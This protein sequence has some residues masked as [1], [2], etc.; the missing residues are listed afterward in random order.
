M[1][2]LA[3][4]DWDRI[5][6]DLDEDGFALTGPIFSEVECGGLT[7]SYD[8]DGAFRS[9]VIM[10]RHGFGLGEYR[11]FQYPLPPI[12]AELRQSIY[13]SLAPLANRWAEAMR[14]EHRYPA[15]LD[16][17]TRRCH[18]A[19]QIK[20]TPLL[21]RYGPGDYNRL[22]RD[23]YGPLAFPIQMTVMLSDPAGFQG[24]EFMLVENRPRMQARGE[25]ITL[26]QGEAVLFAVDQRPVQGTR[27]TF[28][29]SMR[30]GVSRLRSGSRH[31][32]GVI[33]HDAA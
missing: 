7:E 26:G 19:G 29:V 28:R 14:Q 6:A 16:S 10:A 11:Y 33:F 8:D 17:F 13:P 4:L 32:L 15:D 20:P 25:V 30:H 1:K 3:L 22:H 27:G 24:G 9:R 31:T 2:N 21:L 23:L 12:V 18:D 5:T